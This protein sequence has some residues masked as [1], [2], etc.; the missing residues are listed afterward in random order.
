[1]SF[2]QQGSPYC[3]SQLLHMRHVYNKRCTIFCFCKRH[4]PLV[5]INRM[6]CLGDVCRNKSRLSCKCT[7]S[8]EYPTPYPFGV[9]NPDA[10]WFRSIEKHATS[11]LV[12]PSG[13]DVR[14][15]I[16][17]LLPFD[18]S[19][20]RHRC[21]CVTCV[22]NTVNDTRNYYFYCLIYFLHHKTFPLNITMQK[23]YNS[24]KINLQFLRWNYQ[25]KASSFI[26]V[27]RWII[28]T[29]VKI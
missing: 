9:T 23:K 8:I 22:T 25:Q 24:K 13:Y 18:L 2:I 4:L 21:I 16:V 19:L 5:Q 29:M 27:I 3:N 10:P 28:L 15:S 20:N 26:I 6:I 14:Q 1:M 7:S 17:R 12:T 11:E